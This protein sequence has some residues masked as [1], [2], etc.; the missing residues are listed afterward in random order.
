MIRG[1]NSNFKFISSSDVLLNLMF[2]LNLVCEH[3]CREM[4]VRMCVWCVD[5]CVCVCVCASKF[6]IC[7]KNFFRKLKLI[8]NCQH[9]QVFQEVS[10]FLR[11]ANLRFW[12]VLMFSQFSENLIR[13]WNSNFCIK[14]KHVVT[15]NSTPGGIRRNW[16]EKEGVDERFWRCD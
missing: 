2:I 7:E 12:I 5:V 15:K 11:F 16:R 14:K 1:P 8:A 9:C 13:C 10:M 3:S 4:C 6:D